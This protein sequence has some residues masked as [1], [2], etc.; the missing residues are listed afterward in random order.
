MIIKRK[1]KSLL[2][3]LLVSLLLMSTSITSFAT[4]AEPA[5]TNDYILEDYQEIIENSDNV[6]IYDVNDGNTFAEIAKNISARDYESIIGFDVNGNKV[7]NHTSYLTS[8]S[9]TNTRIRQEFAARYGTTVIHNHPSGGSFSPGDLYAEAMFKTPRIIVLSS[10]YVYVLEPTTTGWGDP[11]AM[12]DYCQ[13]RYD[14]YYAEAIKNR[15]SGID[16]SHYAVQ[17]TAVAFNMLYYRCPADQFDFNDST[18]FYSESVARQQ[19]QDYYG[20]SW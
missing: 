18:L 16:G 12:R 7:F 15:T 6:Q 10:K 2:S 4:A 9:Y 17:D 19:Y 5:T 13:Q 3:L 1:F 20:Y 11:T 8:K 14:F